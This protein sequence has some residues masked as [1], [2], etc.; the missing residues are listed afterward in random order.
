MS[1]EEGAVA[2]AIMLQIPIANRE[3]QWEEFLTSSNHLFSTLQTC[4]HQDFPLDDS[5][6]LSMQL[7]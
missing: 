2:K 7:G 1:N 6:V 5:L 4:V 3:P